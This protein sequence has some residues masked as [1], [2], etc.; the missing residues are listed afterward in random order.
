MVEIQDRQV[1]IQ[2]T[3]IAAEHIKCGESDRPPLVF[4]HE[5]LGSIRM[6][7]DF[8]AR[9]CQRSG[10]NG[11]VFDRQGHGRSDPLSSARTF[12]YLDRETGEKLPAVLDALGIEKA[13]FF[14]HS[15]GGTLALLFAARF[16]ERVHCCV[17]EAAHVF[18]EDETRTGIQRAVKAYETTDL[19]ARLEK[20]HGDKTDALFWAWAG[21]WLSDEFLSWNIEEDIRGVKCPL[22][23]LQGEDDEYAT[24]EQV[25]RIAKNVSG[26]VETLL[27]PGCGHVPHLQSMDRTVSISASFLC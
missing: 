1:V 5:A 12:D 16:P 13:A 2:G 6:W 10:L 17:T 20:Y 26:R 18:V 15:D 24:R 19:K 25:D 14:G 4:L 3:T 23:V 21:I 7:K 27:I 22:L 9:L 8:P 11:I